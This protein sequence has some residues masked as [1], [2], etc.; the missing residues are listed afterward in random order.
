MWF[1][2]DP[3]LSTPVYQQ[4][5]DGVRE[6]VAR[7]WL[8]PGERLP[9]V[10]ELAVQMTLNPNTVAKAYQELERQGVIE[11]VRGRGTFVGASPVESES[12][13]AKERVEE[14]VRSILV[15]AHYAGLDGDA[16]VALFAEAVRDWEA[17]KGRD[18]A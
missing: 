13:A 18:Q 9:S 14:A 7:E 10:R 17:G 6:A 12:R 8:R 2:V 1:H 3:R 11:V 16:L 4:V 5:V 15:D